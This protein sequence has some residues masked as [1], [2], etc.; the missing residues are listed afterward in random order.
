M[1]ALRFSMSLLRGRDSVFLKRVDNFHKRKPLVCS[2][3]WGGAK[4]MLACVVAQ[5]MLEKDRTN[6]DTGKVAAFGLWST[7]YCGAFLFLAYGRMFPR[8]WPL[9]TKAGLPHANQ[10]GNR[11][12]MVLFDNFVLTP[13]LMMPSYYLIKSVLDGGRDSVKQPTVA[14]NRA[15]KRYSIEW[16]DS[17]KVVWMF[18]IPIQSVTFSVVPIHWRVPFCATMSLFTMMANSVQQNKLEHAARARDSCSEQEEVEVVCKSGTAVN[19]KTHGQHVDPRAN[20]ALEHV[21]G[22]W[23]NHAIC[24]LCY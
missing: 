10:L 4:G 12:K 23:L 3:F 13:L 2:M 7:V 17:C 8:L 15:V 14:F 19:E 24:Y 1:A 5:S 20:S 18:W 22:V 9:V 6:I 21:K 16:F 11:V